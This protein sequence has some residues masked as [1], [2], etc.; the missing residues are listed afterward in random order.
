MMQFGAPEPTEPASTALKLQD[1]TLSFHGRPSQTSIP[2]ECLQRSRLFRDLMDSSHDSGDLQVPVTR[3][4]LLLWL[5]HVQGS[6]QDLKRPRVDP[7]P[8][9][10]CVASD[11]PATTAADRVDMPPEVPVSTGAAVHRPAAATRRSRGIAGHPLASETL[12]DELS[13][14]DVCVLIKVCLMDHPQAVLSSPI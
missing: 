9:R 12:S 13:A 5:R 14:G 1:G 7:E 4:D 2:A 3:T 6:L 11:E 10:T 8:A